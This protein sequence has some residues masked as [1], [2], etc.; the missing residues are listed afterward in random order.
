MI[1]PRVVECAAAALHNMSAP[2]RSHAQIR[3]LRAGASAPS[4]IDAEGG[5]TPATVVSG[6]SGRFFA[7]VRLTGLLYEGRSHRHVGVDPLS[8]LFGGTPDLVDALAL[9]R[10]GCAT[11]SAHAAAR[12]TCEAL[13]FARLHAEFL[14]RVGALGDQGLPALLLARR[15]ANDLAAPVR[16][17]PAVAFRLLVGTAG[18]VFVRSRAPSAEHFLFGIAGAACTSDVAFDYYLPEAP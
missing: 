6:P 8:G 18:G 15:A 17:E 14:D 12:K 9:L 10:A 16:I 3:P 11:G 7:R 4:S 5:G 13:P 2:P 1:P